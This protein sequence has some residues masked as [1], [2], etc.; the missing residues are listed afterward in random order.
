M[1]GLPDRKGTSRRVTPFR[2]V[3]RSETTGNGDNLS[4]GIGMKMEISN[5]AKVATNVHCHGCFGAI[6]FAKVI[7]QKLRDTF[8]RL[9]YPFHLTTTVF[10]VV[11][12]NT[13]GKYICS[14]YV[15]GIENVP[16]VV[17]RTR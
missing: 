16:Y 3:I 1:R 9:T 17:A 14:A 13:S 2:S 8:A 15:A 7:K 11:R 6:N 10:V 5:A 12:P 4:P